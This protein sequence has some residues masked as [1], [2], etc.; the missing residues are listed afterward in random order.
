MNLVGKLTQKQ[1]WRL[2]LEVGFICLLL[3]LFFII[4]SNPGSLADSGLP[5]AKQSFWQK[6]VSTAQQELSTEPES[7]DG[8][9]RLAISQAMLGL[10]DESM[11]AFQKLDTL[12]KDNSYANE[13][14]KRYGSV[15]VFFN[16]LLVQSYLSFAYYVQEEYQTSVDSFLRVVALDPGNPWPRNYLGFAYYQCGDLDKAI[17]TLE[18]SVSLDP[19]NQYSRSLLGMAYYEAGHILKALKEFAKSPR[20]IKKFL[21]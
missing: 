5:E 7:L 14:I 2:W 6:Q 8:Y 12:D 13:V 3:T 4:W 16:D 19:Q 1:N 9:F 21:Q 11:D 15:E 17:K 10:I 20:V 18:T